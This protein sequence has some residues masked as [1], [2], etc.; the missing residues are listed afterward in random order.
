M[1]DR[2]CQKWFVKL[3]AGDFLLDDAPWLSTPVEVDRDQIENNQCY[4]MRETDNILK[5]SKSMKLL[6][7]MKN[8]SFISCQ[9]PYRYFSQPHRTLSIVSPL[10]HHKSPSMHLLKAGVDLCRETGG[11]FCSRDC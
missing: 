11:H 6:V 9:E 10:Y 2:M 1:T 5:I 3:R 7:K 4:A 8:V